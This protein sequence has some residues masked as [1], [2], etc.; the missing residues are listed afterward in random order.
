M[1]LE[2]QIIEIGKFQKPHALKGELNALLDIDPDYMDNKPLVVNT[3]GIFVPFFIESLREKGTYSYLIKLEGVDSEDEA[4]KFVNKKIF[5]M[6]KD[7]EEWI[8]NQETELGNELIGYQI[9]DSKTSDE[10]G[11]IVAIEQNTD[12]PLFIVEKLGEEFYI[13]VTDDF[14][15]EIDDK[16]KIIFMDLPDGLIDINK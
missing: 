1:I 16:D 14:I 8:E 9:K 7:V 12:N 5:M 15:I 3:D 4:K 13:P 2:A 6:R 10:I 11:R